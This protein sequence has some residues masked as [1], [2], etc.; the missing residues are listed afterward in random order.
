MLIGVLSTLDSLGELS[1]GVGEAFACLGIEVEVTICCRLL[2]YRDRVA[3][4]LKLM[5]VAL[6]MVSE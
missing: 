2:G 1:G 6:T 3:V 5:Q 4:E